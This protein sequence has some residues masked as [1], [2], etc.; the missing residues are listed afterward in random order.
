MT[1]HAAHTAA[2][3]PALAR[4]KALPWSTYGLAAIVAAYLIW[5]LAPVVIAFVFSFNAGRSRSIW[6]GFS[7]EWWSGPQSVFHDPIYQG[8]IRHSFLL[9]V[10]AVVISVPL[11]VSLSVFLARWRGVTS[12]PASF[13]STLPLV[14][15]E[16]VLALSLFFL[17]TKALHFMSLGT[18]AQVVGQVTFI[19]PVIIV[20]TRGRLTSLPVAYEEAAMDLGASPLTAFRLVLVPL[21]QPAILASAVV[22]FAVSIDDFVITQYMSSDAST[23][24]VP[25]LIYNTGRG[26]APPALNAAATVMALTTIVVSA[27]GYLLYTLLTRREQLGIPS[28]EGVPDDVALLGE[29]G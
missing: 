5:S 8:A 27:L 3:R 10:L 18:T 17:V 6:Q 7:T 26:S 24:T 16:L 28:T 15:P 2:P 1:G 25:M 23:Q 29:A 9:A 4:L 13:L 21:L 19:L 20:I 22:A 12:K 14:I 11:G